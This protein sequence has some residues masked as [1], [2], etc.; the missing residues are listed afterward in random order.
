MRFMHTGDWQMGLRAAQAGGKAREVRKARFQTAARI[1]D[2]ARR[3]KVDFVLLAGDTFEDHD[4]DEVDVGRT[5]EALNGFAPIPV[6]VLPGNHDPLGAGSVWERRSW[7]DIG[8]HVRLLEA[9]AP[10][11]LPGDAVLYPCPLRQKRSSLDPTAWIPSREAG[12]RR[13]RIGLA[14]GALKVLPQADN[15]PIAPDRADRCSLDYL[16]LGDWHGFRAFDRTVYSGTPEQTAFD[17]RD[18]GNVAL[19]DIAAAGE[20]PQVRREPVGQ[21]HWAGFHCDMRDP[22]DVVHLE[23]DIRK[24]GDPARLLARVVCDVA[25]GASPE[26]VERVEQLRSRL[27]QD[28]LLLR[29]E[30]ETAG[31]P[32]AAHEIPE[33]IFR[34]TAED[35]E[36][37]LADRLPQGPAG[38]LR[39]TDPAVLRT[40]RDLLDRLA[41]EVRR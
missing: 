26:A 7:Q 21:L 31:S 15:F 33:G 17:E 8:S 19:V 24:A 35:L 25:P 28:A 9:N 27:A 30:G 37:L 29:W 18:P 13:I 2:L 12:D 38:A 11:D 22:S 34:R 10:V 41:G 36:D 23:A 14:H 5:V 32:L 1:A 20:P 16:A 3:E 39:G 4:V 6:Y 40:A